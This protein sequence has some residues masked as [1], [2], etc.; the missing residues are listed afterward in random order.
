MKYAVL[1]L[2]LWF[3]AP[4]CAIGVDTD[5]LADPAYEARAR[6]LME[7][8]RC[9]VCQNQSIA[10]S[11]AALAEDL[12]R[13]V[14]ERISAGDSDADIK[15]YLVQRYGNWILLDPPIAPAT[16]LLWFGPLLVLGGG[17]AVYVRCTRRRIDD[18]A[19]LTDSERQSLDNLP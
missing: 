14:R 18:V 8:L 9:L 5:V 16:W 15:A 10:D 2:C 4:A 12:R 19:P 1:L 7:E 6:S 17:V 13:I 11:D 3:S